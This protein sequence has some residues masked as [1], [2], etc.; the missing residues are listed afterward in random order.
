MICAVLEKHCKVSFGNKDVYLNVM[1]GL[2]VNEPAGDLAVL[3]AIL[4]SYLNI[5]LP[6]S[7][8]AFG[9]IGLSGE[10]RNVH[11][12]QKRI[13][14]A[15]KLGCKGIISASVDEQ[16]Q[17]IITLKNVQQALNWVKNLKK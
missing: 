8:V 11:H 3:L 10:I 13:N 16:A 17:E 6:T 2:R 15:R 5:P 14:E 7:F 1:G 12:T 9:E 4:S